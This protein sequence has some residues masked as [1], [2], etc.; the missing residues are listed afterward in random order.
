MIPEVKLLV[1]DTRWGN[2]YRNYH[3]KDY[4]GEAIVQFNNTNEL[5]NFIND[6]HKMIKSN[7]ITFKIIK[8]KKTRTTKF[9]CDVE[10][11]TLRNYNLE[12]LEI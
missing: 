3:E 9:Y 2:V 10:A 4:K 6:G 8:R 12:I 5:R 7:G 1:L 11:L